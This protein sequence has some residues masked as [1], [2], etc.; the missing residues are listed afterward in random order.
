MIEPVD[1][2]HKKT[3][4]RRSQITSKKFL[5]Y[6]DLSEV[7]KHSRHFSY[8]RIEA[9][10]GNG[11]GGEDK[12]FLIREMWCV[13][14]DHAWSNT[15][16]YWWSFALCSGNHGDHKH[17]LQLLRGNAWDIKVR[18]SVWYLNAFKTAV[19]EAAHL[20]AESRTF[21]FQCENQVPRSL[22]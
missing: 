2:L 17:L 7:R 3:E 4:R 5:V 6:L 19:I 13:R 10:I 12:L 18:F 15:M 11:W 21:Y 16:W 9:E 8:L 22:S 1:E 20:E 14:Q